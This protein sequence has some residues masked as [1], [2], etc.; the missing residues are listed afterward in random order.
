MIN[1][2]HEK[3]SMSIAMRVY[4][5]SCLDGDSTRV[6]SAPKISAS[7]DRKKEVLNRNVMLY[8]DDAMA[9]PQDVIAIKEQ[10]QRFCPGWNV[11]LFSKET[12]YSFMLDEYGEEIA[13]LFLTCALPAM[14]CDFFRVFWAIAEGGIYSDVRFVP[15]REPLF[16]DSSKD[17][18]V[19]RKPDGLIRNGTFFG[20]MGCMELKLIAYELMV[21]VSMK[22]IR[23]VNVATGPVLWTKTLPKNDTDT[24]SIIDWRKDMLTNIE[25]SIFPSCT[26]DT[27]RHWIQQQRRMSI[28]CDPASKSNELLRGRNAFNRPKIPPPPPDQ[29]RFQHRLEALDQA[30]L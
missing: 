23:E 2:G 11:K 1:S 20:K 29:N 28:Y 24:L 26:R 3:G 22:E 21:T 16:F 15:L 17:L 19:G 25:F 9:L 14:R 10:W 5:S 27:E 13:S 7:A 6:E 8:W 30:Y 18:T 4:Q 12:A